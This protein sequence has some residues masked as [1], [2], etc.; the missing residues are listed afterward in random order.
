MRSSKITRDKILK[1]AEK[2]FA[3]KG[4]WGAKID[5]IA[6]AA[7]IN[8]RLIYVHFGSKEALYKAVL[9]NVYRSLNGIGKCIDPALSPEKAIESFVFESFDFLSKNERAVRIMMWE[10]LNEAEFMTGPEMGDMKN[11]TAA[12]LKSIIR[13]GIKDGIFKSDTDE[14]EVA[15]EI[16]MLVLS[17]YSNNHTLP[18]L[19]GISAPAKENRAKTVT[20]TILSRIMNCF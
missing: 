10:N 8:K 17:F 16:I 1:A 4:Y 6:A 5:E 2:A 9:Q 13:T 19:I 3:E 7:Q 20:E 12:L 11:D 18:K 15:F 14:N